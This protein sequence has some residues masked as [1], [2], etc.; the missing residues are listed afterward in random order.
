MEETTYEY[1]PAEAFRWLVGSPLLGIALGIIGVRAP[2]VSGGLWLR[3]LV[4]LVGVWLLLVAIRRLINPIRIWQN[5]DHVRVEYLFGLSRIWK[6]DGLRIDADARSLGEGSVRVVDG[7][8]IPVFRIFRDVSGF[9]DL[10]QL[11]AVPSPVE[12]S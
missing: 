1:T 12:S 8:G 9:R 2:V 7:G 10:M 5:G 4:V 11:I 3:S 6:F